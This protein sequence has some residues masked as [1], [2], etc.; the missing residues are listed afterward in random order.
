MAWPIIPDIPDNPDFP[1]EDVN[2]VPEELMD[3]KSERPDF[4]SVMTISIAELHECGF[5]DLTREDWD[6]NPKYSDEQHAKLCEKITAHYWYR[7]ISLVPPGIW[8]HE[9]LRT[10]N[11]IMPKYMPFYEML[12]KYPN[13]FNSDS[14]YYKARN[15]Y[16]D[17]PQTQLNGNNGD[18][19]STGND[20]EYER[21]RQTNI[22]DL[23][24]RLRNYRDVD[25]MIIDEIETLFSCLMTVNLNAF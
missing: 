1:A 4:H 9:F 2:P 21:I 13:L 3:L 19:A 15:I 24:D 6:F 22:L 8:K 23:F 17:F 7:D 14:E 11:E 18:Y 10:M 5:F 16:S 25:A 12:E 20:T